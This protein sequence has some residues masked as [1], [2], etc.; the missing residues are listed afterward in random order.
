MESQPQRSAA[1]STA[2]VDPKLLQ[3]IE[4]LAVEHEKSLRLMEGMAVENE[5]SRRRTA[6]L[7]AELQRLRATASKQRGGAM[8]D[9]TT[10]TK[11][12][13][14]SSDSEKGNDDAGSGSD[15]GV[16]DDIAWTRRIRRV[17]LQEEVE[18]DDDAAAHS[19]PSQPMATGRVRPSS[20]HGSRDYHVVGSGHN[21]RAVSTKPLTTAKPFKVAERPTA[22]TRGIA[23]RRRMEE[24]KR[25]EEEE[26]ELAA[27]RQFKAKPIPKTTTMPLYEKIV[28]Q[29][30]AARQL[31]NKARKEVS[32]GSLF[33]AT[34]AGCHAKSGR[35]G[36]T[37][38]DGVR[39]LS[40]FVGRHALVHQ[41]VDSCLV[42]HTQGTGCACL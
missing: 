28:R 18:S 6:E 17:F 15:A 12:E 37:V 38:F 5:Q 39:P 16:E 11:S 35:S 26:A 22:S 23:A 9:D 27:A 7:E 25:R 20:A 36:N 10:D 41:Q 32:C 14:D 29:Q 1:A 3:K 42:V 8:Y 33:A 31:G 4:S 30:D 19:R 40:G 24:Q 21:R 13:H 2:Q 34:F